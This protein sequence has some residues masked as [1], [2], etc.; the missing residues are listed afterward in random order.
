[1]GSGPFMFSFKRL[2]LV[3][4]DRKL[5]TEI[6]TSLVTSLFS[7]PR[8][9]LVGG[10]GSMVAALVTAWK[11]GETSLI[12]CAVGI[13]AVTLA[14]AADMRAFANAPQHPS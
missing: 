7:D 4:H 3:G 10:L 11:S 14:R 5:P 12:V 9:L 2:I 13:V 1:M 8:T 6:Y